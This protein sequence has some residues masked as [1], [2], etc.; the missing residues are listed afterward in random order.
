M[1]KLKQG[2]YT[3][4]SSLTLSENALWVKNLKL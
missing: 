4:N 3:P 2:R 1:S